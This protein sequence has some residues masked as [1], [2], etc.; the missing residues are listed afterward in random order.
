MSRHNIVWA[1][2]LC[3]IAL[4]IAAGVVFYI[5]SAETA[6]RLNPPPVRTTDSMLY[7]TELLIVMSVRFLIFGLGVRKRIGLALLLS[8]LGTVAI[9]LLPD[10]VAIL[11]NGVSRD[12]WVGLIFLIIDV[13]VPCV[14]ASAILAAVPIFDGRASDRLKPTV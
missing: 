3:G 1:V 8:I 13:T 10:V 7:G 6:D 9:P 2:R 12:F 14:V 11:V 4:A 5:L